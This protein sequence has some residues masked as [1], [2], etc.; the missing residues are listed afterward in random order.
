M[1]SIS[2]QHRCCNTKL[3]ASKTVRRASSILKHFYGLAGT[4]YNLKTCF[5]IF[6]QV[7][8]IIVQNVGFLQEAQLK[9]TSCQLEL[10]LQ[11]KKLNTVLYIISTNVIFQLNGLKDWLIH[12]GITE[13]LIYACICHCCF[14][15]NKLSDLQLE[16]F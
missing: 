5:V 9:I 16:G 7:V 11:S 2:I 3:F 10:V 12:T 4:C 6:T 13:L 14:C 15:W 8:Q 1:I